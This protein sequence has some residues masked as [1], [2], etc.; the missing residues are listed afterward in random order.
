ML[1]HT[2][3][4]DYYHYEWLN[5]RKTTFPMKKHWWQWQGKT[6]GGRPSSLT[7][8][9]G[10]DDEEQWRFEE[11]TAAQTLLP[12]TK[13]EKKKPADSRHNG[14]I[15]HWMMMISKMTHSGLTLSHNDAV[16]HDPL[17]YSLHFSTLHF[18]YTWS[19]FCLSVVLTSRVDMETSQRDGQEDD[20]W[21]EF[22]TVC[23]WKHA[24]RSTACCVFWSN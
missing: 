4:V 17:Q 11:R 5:H 21:C 10:C 12:K 8:G 14:F 1:R 19:V 2:F 22:Q 16:I 20:F 18:I 7:S 13:P 6:L 24:S 3:T 9:V 23:M 15:F